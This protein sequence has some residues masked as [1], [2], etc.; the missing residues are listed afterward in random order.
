MLLN[1]SLNLQKA[2]EQVTDPASLRN[3]IMYFCD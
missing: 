1:Q 3:I 2:L